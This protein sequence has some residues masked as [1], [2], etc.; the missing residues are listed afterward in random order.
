MTK[1]KLQHYAEFYLAPLPTS[2]YAVLEVLNPLTSL[3]K[4][5]ERSLSGVNIP[6]EAFGYRFFDRMECDSQIGGSL[7][8]KILNPSSSSYFGKVVTMENMASEVPNP[9][10]LESLMIE[11]GYK[12]MVKTIRENF[13]PLKE[14]MLSCQIIN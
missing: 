9:Q 7:V 12:K 5:K 1:E 2:P 6:E 8:G 4:V 14:A 3:V 11:K 10:L 13:H